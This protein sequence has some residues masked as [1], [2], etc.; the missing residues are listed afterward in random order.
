MLFEA[1]FSAIIPIVLA[2]IRAGTFFFSLKIE[3]FLASQS[4]QHRFFGI[5]AQRRLKIGFLLRE[6][7]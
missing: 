5:E 3:L 7:G 1:K 2:A 6:P 4:Y